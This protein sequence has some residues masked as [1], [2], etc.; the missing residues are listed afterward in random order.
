MTMFTNGYSSLQ[1]PEDVE[2]VATK[3]EFND[4]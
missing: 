3:E 1:I 4:L 2:P